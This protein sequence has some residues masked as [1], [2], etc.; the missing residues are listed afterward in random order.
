MTKVAVVY[1]SGFGHTKLQ[2]EAIYNGANTLGGAE[3]RL[4]TTAEASEQLDELDHY[5]A[6][7]FGSPTYMGSMSAEVKGFFEKA[8]AMWFTQAWKNKI[9]GVFTNSTSFSGDKLNTQ[10]SMLINAMQHGM[11]HVSLGLHPAQNNP[12]SKKSLLGP[13][14][15]E[16]NRVGASLGPMATSME[17]APGEGPSTG[18]LETARL[19]GERVASITQQLLRGRQQ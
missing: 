16:L 6:I 1:H 8:A 7:I 3:A 13:G 10:F 14:E 18:D 4:F 11:I 5:D 2:A 15:R 17:V 12:D 9:S 19:Y